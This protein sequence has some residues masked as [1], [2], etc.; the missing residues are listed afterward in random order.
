MAVGTA[1]S[2]RDHAGA[3][4][5]ATAMAAARG[6]CVSH[7]AA[8]TDGESGARTGPRHAAS[9]RRILGTAA[10]SWRTAREVPMVLVVWAR[11]LRAGQLGAGQLGAGQ[12]GAGQLRA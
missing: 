1:I 4:A 12:L 2:L 7:G 11:Q 5:G 9:P 8:V 6:G 3:P 10:G